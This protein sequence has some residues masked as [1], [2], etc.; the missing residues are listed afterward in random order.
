[1][2]DYLRVKIKGQLK[3]VLDKSSVAYVVIE[4]TSVM[5]H[6]KVPYVKQKSCIMN[7]H[8]SHFIDFS[9]IWLWFTDWWSPSSRYDDVIE[10]LSQ[11]HGFEDSTDKFSWIITVQYF[12]PTT[13][14]CNK[15][16]KHY[17][18]MF[19]FCTWYSYFLPIFMARLTQA[20]VFV[21]LKTNLYSHHLALMSRLHVGAY[22]LYH[23]KI[24][25]YSNCN[26]SLPN[27]SH[28]SNTN[29]TFPNRDKLK[30][31]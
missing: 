14:P 23:W 4:S 13:N 7:S 9:Y 29:S 19:P 27:L 25:Q 17:R 31:C 22:G 10:D 11:K 28:L 5:T 12:W 16:K 6:H 18:N 8:T 30:H 1:M 24:A 21:T 26:E 20:R 2:I 3:V 15:I